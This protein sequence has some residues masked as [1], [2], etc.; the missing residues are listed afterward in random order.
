MYNI[1]EQQ[2]NL[3]KALRRTVFAQTVRLLL[4]SLRAVFLAYFALP[5]QVKI[6]RGLHEQR[7]EEGRTDYGSTMNL[8][9]RAADSNR[10][11]RY[12]YVD[13]LDYARVM[14][15]RTLECIRMHLDERGVPLADFD[16]KV[17]IMR[18]R[19]T[20]YDFEREP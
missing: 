7:N 12:P 14:R 19:S 13:E 9:L 16:E 3:R 20:A 15:D 4:Q 10:M 2:R 8:R 6:V 11:W 5:G 17:R 18:E 1:P